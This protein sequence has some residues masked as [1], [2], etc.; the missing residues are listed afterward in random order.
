MNL[1][2][3]SYSS[4][5]VN[6]KVE[7]KQKPAGLLMSTLNLINSLLGAGVLSVSNSF[8]F[9]G[10]LPSMISLTLVAILSTISA[11]MVV[12]MHFL[13]KCHSFNELALICTGRRFAIITEISCTFFCFSC[14]TAYLILGADIV[15]EWL[16]MI[17]FE[18]SSVFWQRS[19]VVF[20]FAICFPIPL[21]FPRHFGFIKFVS[22]L[23][24]IAL[25]FFFISILIRG[26]EK[27]SSQG[28]SQ[29]TSNSILSI[30]IFTTLAM[31]S[32]AFALAG[33]IIPVISVSKPSL[34]LRWRSTG[35]TFFLSYLIVM[36]PG[37]IG[38]LMFGNE[39]S[40]NI[41]QNFESKDILFQFVKVAYFVVLVAAYPVIGLP[42]QT[43]LGKYIYHDVHTAELASSKRNLV[44]LLENAPCLLIALFLPKVRPAIAIGGAIGGGISN[45]I[46]PSLAMLNFPDNSHTIIEKIALYLYLIFGIFATVLA[47]YQS[48][49]DA[50]EIFKNTK[51]I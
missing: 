27:F 42:I 23:S 13:S 39:T 43:T 35:L 1:S 47:T 19:L 33:I 4:K 34:R 41:L 30:K 3:T 6:E 45:F 2:E 37:V 5:D 20:C 46:F 15:L 10:F 8:V 51:I 24:F 49:V 31:H 32:L 28:I 12:K 14:M 22:V 25:S 48:I 26:I 36:I 21:T 44:L 50:I 9:C 18:A 38:Y 40:D 7:V 16:N 11:A 17:G 29:T